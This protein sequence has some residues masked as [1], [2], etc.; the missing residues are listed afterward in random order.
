[1]NRMEVLLYVI[2]LGVVVNLIANMIWKYIPSTD[3]HLDKIVSA[4]LICICILLLIFV[5]QN[6]AGESHD[7]SRTTQSRDTTIKNL[8]VQVEKVE[9]GTGNISIEN[10]QGDKIIVN[11]N[12]T[13][14]AFDASLVELQRILQHRAEKVEAWLHEQQR[15]KHSASSPRQYDEA[16]Q[17]F[18]RLHKQHI[19]ALKDSTVVFC[20]CWCQCDTLRPYPILWVKGPTS[21]A[22]SHRSARSHRDR[23]RGHFSR[24][25]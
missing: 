3:K 11:E 9:I 12:N 18:Q 7:K 16:I 14:A 21:Q 19:D 17:A 23:P 20:H 15:D 6:V 10:V 1:M 25:L 2:I 24:S 4:I 8:G 22:A 5:R 13:T